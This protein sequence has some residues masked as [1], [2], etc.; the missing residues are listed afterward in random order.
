MNNANDS[1]SNTE[2]VA[3]LLVSLGK[4]CV[5]TLTPFLT[6]NE[7]REIS[8]CIHEMHEINS[9]IA[10]KI[11]KEFYYKLS[12]TTQFPLESIG[13]D[14][15]T[16]E[17]LDI[18]ESTE[19]KQLFDYLQNEPLL[20]IATMLSYLEPLR[21]TEILKEFPWDQQRELIL[22]FD[23]IPDKDLSSK[24]QQMGIANFLGAIISYLNQD[25]KQTILEE[26]QK[27]R[28]A[29]FGQIVS[30]LSETKNL[31]PSLIQNG[32]EY[33]QGTNA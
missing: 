23:Q 29:L 30:M 11:I 24:M 12:L 2:K 13:Q 3:L 9:F 28:P 4:E 8:H 19:P 26:L 1:L 10:S 7:L 21:C 18:L 14:G 32:A 5:Q 16:Q 33:E 20:S 22:M 15:Y 31:D 17:V 25:A 27:K 6:E